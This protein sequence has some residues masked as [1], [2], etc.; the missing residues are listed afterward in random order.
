MD[1]TPDPLPTIPEANSE[2]RGGSGGAA[3]PYA[4]IGDD[5]VAARRYWRRGG[6]RRWLL[7]LRRWEVDEGR[8]ADSRGRWRVRRVVGVQRPARRHGRQLDVQVEWAG[9]DT[10]SGEAW[11]VEWIPL[12]QR[13]RST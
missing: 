12:T 13:R 11:G 8:E 10:T 6:G 7:H 3:V 2:Q 9:V 1:T 4:I 5:A